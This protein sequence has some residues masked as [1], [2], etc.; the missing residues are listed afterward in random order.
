MSHLVVDIGNTRTTVARVTPRGRLAAIRHLPTSAVRVRAVAACLASVSRGRPVEG[1]ILSSVVPARDAAW[2]HALAGVC[3]TPPLRL[4]HRL[5]L[6][7]R[8]GYARPV[9]LG[10]DRIADVCGAVARYGAPVIVADFGTAATFNV[11][12]ADR[13][14]LGGVIAP[15]PSLMTDYLADRTARLP[16]IS[17]SGRLAWL[18]RDTRTAIRIAAR[19][20]YAAMARGVLDHLRAAPGWGR[21]RLVVTGGHA[22]GVARDLNR[23]A[24]VDPWLTLHGLSAIYKLNRPP[25]AARK[26]RKAR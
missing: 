26:E 24:V 6:N 17:A 15:G 19:V 7:V 8:L 14:F 3:R 10:V 22:R 2:I 18:G 5:Q 25:P 21:A 20:G 1:A 12:S 4:T 11:V 23:A 13:V 16:R 9:T